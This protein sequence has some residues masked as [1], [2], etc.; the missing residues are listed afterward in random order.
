MPHSGGPACFVSGQ[1]V[2]RR[3]VF[4]GTITYP[5]RPLVPP[6]VTLRN[7]IEPDETSA[8]GNR[9]GHAWPLDAGE[10]GWDKRLTRTGRN[11]QNTVVCSQ[12][13]RSLR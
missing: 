9:L 5:N 10:V 6:Y 2:F 4:L 1:R 8:A 3:I 7:Q 11:S 13:R 12:P